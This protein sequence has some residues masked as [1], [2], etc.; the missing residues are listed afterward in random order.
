MKETKNMNIYEKMLAVTSELKTVG[1][2]LKVQVTQKSSY[3]AV[4]EKDILDEVKPL[5]EKFGIYSYPVERKIINE[6]IITTKTDYGEKNSF[7]MRI[8]TKYRFVNVSNPEDYIDVI[9]YGDGIDT[10][11]KAPGKAVTYSDKYALMK[12][13]KISTGDDPDKEASPESGYK[14][15]SKATAKQVEILEKYYRGDNLT[16]LL[17]TNNIS[18]L[19]DLPIRK[20]SEIIKKLTELNK[21]KQEE[22]D[23]ARE[24]QAEV[25][26]AGDR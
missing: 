17:Q 7:F 10:G 20:A 1:K 14:T 16:K 6:D 22:I 19:K 26:E 5:E 3:N 12:A 8:E 2:N 15:S 18:S 13:Y 23:L 24:G 11:D 25:E 21:E 9:A 4:S